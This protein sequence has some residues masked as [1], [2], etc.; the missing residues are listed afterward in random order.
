[1]ANPQVLVK[2]QEEPCFH[3]SYSQISTYLGC[4]LKYRFNYVEKRPYERISA[5]LFL[6]SAIHLAIER[7]YQTIRN[8]ETREQLSVLEEMVEHS[9]AVDCDL[10][11]VPVIFKQ[12]APD[13]QSLINQGKGLIR[14]FYESVDL[15]GYEIVS[16][17]MP[18]S[19]RIYNEE[20]EPTDFRLVGAIDLL[21]RDE[22]GELVIVDNKTAARAKSQADVDEDL[23]F[24][25]YSFLLV[26]TGIAFARSNIKCRMDVLR[27]TKTPKLEQYHSIRTPDA[28]LR[29]SKIANAVLA[30]ISAGVFIP[31]S[32]WLCADCQF[33][34]ACRQW[35]LP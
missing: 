2:F 6:G 16:V 11:D 26:S 32:G 7:Y 14:M 34:N 35:H 21:L 20:G 29:F 5:S 28:R 18:V 8:K 22:N 1:M 31:N 13:R 10:T 4:G 25:A 33:S 27:K 23:Q 24:S 9:L 15:T 3:L 19:A 30:G 17:E 12:E